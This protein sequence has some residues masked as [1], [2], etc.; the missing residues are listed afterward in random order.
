[1]ELRL[2]FWLKL[3]TGDLSCTWQKRNWKK[4][5][6]FWKSVENFSV[7]C[8][9]LLPQHYTR[10][11]V[12]LSHSP[13]PSNIQPNSWLKFHDTCQGRGR[14][15]ST[16]AL[17]GTQNLTYNKSSK[18]IARFSVWTFFKVI[19]WNK[20]VVWVLVSTWQFILVAVLSFICQSSTWAEQGFCV[21]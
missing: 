15:V 21:W 3:E 16:D 13:V 4:K 5:D 11:T 6:S 19:C 8:L 10:D 1:M 17:Q 9:W 20:A 7:A 2:F 12:I 14:L 18:N